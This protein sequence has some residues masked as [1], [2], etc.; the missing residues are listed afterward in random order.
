LTV[1]PSISGVQ[2]FSFDVI[3]TGTERT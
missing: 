3:I 2:G 1:S